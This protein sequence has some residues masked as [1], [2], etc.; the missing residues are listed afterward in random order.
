M[1]L[2][3]LAL[4]SLLSFS[5]ATG[6]SSCKKSGDPAGPATNEP[7]PD[8]TSTTSASASG[9]VVNENNLPASGATVR[10]GSA[11]ATTD[12]TGYFSFSNVAVIR[13]TATVSVAMTGY[14]TGT[15]SFIAEAGKSVFFR[16]KLLKK[17][18]AG[19]IPSATGGVVTLTNGLRISFPANSVKNAATGASFSG[20]FSVAAQWIDPT[21]SELNSLMPG[22]LRALNASGALNQLTTYGMAA[23]EL[24]A[25][26]GD[27]LQLAD[28]KQATLTMPLPVALQSS[29]PATLPLWYFDETKGLW[30]EE[31]SATKTGTTYQGTVSHFS[32]WNCDVGYP[33]VHFNATITNSSGVGVNNALIRIY[34]ANRPSDVHFGYT[35]GEGYVSGGVPPNTALVLEVAGNA[36]C[37]TPL[38]SHPFTTGTT[39]IQLGSLA[40]PASAT[41]QVSGT[42]VDCNGA[43]VTNGSLLVVQGNQYLRIA[44][45]SSGAFTF[46]LPVCGSNNSVQLTGQDLAAGVQSSPISVNLVAGANSAGALS[47]CAVNLAEFVNYTLNGVATSYTNP[48][49]NLGV[50]QLGDYEVFANRTANTSAFVRFRFSSSGIAA[51]ANLALT[52]FNCT[53]IGNPTAPPTSPAFVHI[54][55]YGPIGG[56]IAGNVTATISNTTN[57]GSPYSITCNF[58]VKRWF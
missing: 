35:N 33:Y 27:R 21:S 44:V 11:T 3:R 55:E 57:P 30:I 25:P 36:G 41:A 16:I 53:G 12:A 58:R 42:V 14:F 52:R 46:V 31:G 6:L 40:L 37:A 15:K 50:S 29:A 18:I 51:N 26:N 23:V 1:E 48:P 34:P 32:F 39:D 5:L 49:D 54:T 2:A 56:Y 8:L 43:G 20:T 19:T 24:M 17:T 47:A 38:L 10:M 22:D 4:L 28:G 13:N 9:F 7:A 45:N